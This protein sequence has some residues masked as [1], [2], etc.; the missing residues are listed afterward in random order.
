MQERPGGTERDAPARAHLSRHREVARRDPRDGAA[1]GSSPRADTAR[2]SRAGRKS[3]P[4]RAALKSYGRM[5]TGPMRKPVARRFTP[6]RRA[7]QFAGHPDSKKLVSRSHT[8]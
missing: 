6:G 3:R 8:G 1:P 2:D 7:A 4:Q 5:A